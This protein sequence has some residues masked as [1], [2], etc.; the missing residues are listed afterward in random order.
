M[1]DRPRDTDGSRS[2]LTRSA[3]ESELASAPDA[4]IDAA[5]VAGYERCHQPEHDPWAEASARRS[6]NAESW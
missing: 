6:I 2:D 4:A 1:T 5:I 3:I